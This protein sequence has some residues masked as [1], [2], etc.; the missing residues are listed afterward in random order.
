[1]GQRVI[2]TVHRAFGIGRYRLTDHAEAER[3][4]DTVSIVEL[5]HALT[6][7]NLELL[8]NYPDDPRGAS[9][10]MLGFTETGDPIHVVVGLASTEVV[11][12]VTVYR[13]DPL[14]WYDWRERAFK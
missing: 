9:A 7:P 11:V 8:E 2:E 1:M 12:V 4:A 14:L 5:E 10:L 13:P 3:E 6:S